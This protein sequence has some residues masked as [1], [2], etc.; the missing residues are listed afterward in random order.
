MAFQYTEIKIECSCHTRHY[1]TFKTIKF[2]GEPNESDIVCFVQRN[3]SRK[4]SRLLKSRQMTAR[5]PNHASILQLSRVK[6]AWLGS[7][8]DNQGRRVAS[9]FT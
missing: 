6:K 8:T 5:H 4:I 9:A 2:G 7:E 3:E 1:R